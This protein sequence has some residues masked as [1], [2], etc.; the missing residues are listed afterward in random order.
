MK[1]K[2]SLKWFEHQQIKPTLRTMFYRLVSLEIIPNTKQSYK[3]LS[4]AT[5]KARK[6]GEIPWDCF[7]DQSQLFHKQEATIIVYP[8]KKR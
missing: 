8:H 7:S 6:L 4:S 3:S 1:T 2:D 5:V